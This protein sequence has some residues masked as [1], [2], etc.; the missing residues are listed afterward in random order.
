LSAHPHEHEEWL[1]RVLAGEADSGSPVALARLADCARC[2][3]EMERL[4]ALATEL[5]A[6]AARE[7]ADIERAGSERL[8]AEEA[9]VRASLSRAHP[10]ER[11]RR[12]RSFVLALAAAVALVLLGWAVR[13]VL[14]EEPPPE[15]YLGGGIA[16][17]A[18]IG[19]G[20]DLGEFRWR[21][22]LPAFGSYTLRVH[23][24]TDGGLRGEELLVIPALIAPRW[25]PSPEER[26]TFPDAIAWEI[27]A[28]EAMGAW[29]ARGR[30]TASR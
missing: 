21:Y 25:T 3:R 8:P 18:P 26:A 6:F 15:V 2:R 12:R 13:G 4:G 27:E 24:V 16:C 30:A 23:A 9:L 5:R 1:A 19:A 28:F 20:S 7:R 14:R 17:E 29:L 11:P 22:A 10:V